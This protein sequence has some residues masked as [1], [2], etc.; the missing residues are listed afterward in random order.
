[1]N[2]K[3][4]RGWPGPTRDSR[5]LRRVRFG[6]I[7]RDRAEMERRDAGGILKEGA[8]CTAREDSPALSSYGSRFTTSVAT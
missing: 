3:M 2:E 8:D 6:F 5:Q 7:A 1:M 4:P